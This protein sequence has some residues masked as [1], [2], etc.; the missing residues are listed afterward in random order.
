MRKIVY[1][2]LLC[3]ANTFRLTDS[4]EYKADQ[5][6]F[7]TEDTVQSTTFYNLFNKV[8]KLL[9]VYI[10]KNKGA[11]GDC[12]KCRLNNADLNKTDL[13]PADR[14]KV[15]KKARAH[16]K[17]VRWIRRNKA[18]KMLRGGMCA[19]NPGG[20]L[21][22][23]Q[24]EQFGTCGVWRSAHGWDE[25]GQAPLSCQLNTTEVLSE[26]HPRVYNPGDFGAYV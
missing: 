7:G 8:L 26:G 25:Q 14:E 11:S 10:R 2:N 23:G 16:R 22:L 4:Q 9:G 17:D 12:D 1:T 21:P 24:G 18:L 13:L 20:I 6:D 5:H 3:V 15:Q 19:S